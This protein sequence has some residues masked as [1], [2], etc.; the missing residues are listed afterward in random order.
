MGFSGFPKGAQAF[1][2]DLAENNDRIWF[3]DNRERYERDLLGPEREFVDA[4]GTAF[5]A[6]DERVHADSGANRSIFRINRDTR[7]SKDKS[8]Y[9]THAD[10][11]FWI[12]DDRKTSPAGYFV[13]LI[14]DAVWIGGGVHTLTDKQL[15]R[16][17]VAV[18][19]GVQGPRLEHI[20]AD[21]EG[22]GFDVGEQTLKRAP[23][24]YSP[25]HPRIELL[26]YT[27]IHAMDKVSPSPP[28]IESEAFV[29]WCMERFAHTKPLVDWLA[30]QLSGENP[31]D[32]RL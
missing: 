5:A 18:A 3:A 12:G 20:L 4:I 19:D 24:G 30:S 6:I 16:Y 15:T 11:W 10:L 21:L 17:R 8:P 7:F 2:A 31:P 14:P 22:A 26:R 29:G 27:S 1:L 28:Q 23:A 13:R 25:Q 9:K 32:L